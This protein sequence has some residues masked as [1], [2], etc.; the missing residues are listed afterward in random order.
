MDWIDFFVKWID[1]LDVIV[2]VLEKRE[3]VIPPDDLILR[4]FRETPLNT[5]KI[6]I[7]G[8]DP[9]PHGAADGLAFSVHPDYPSCGDFSGLSRRPWEILE[10]LF[11][12][13]G[14]QKKKGDLTCW[15]RQGV[16]LLNLAL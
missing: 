5:L 12:E 15:A 3:N 9:Y 2:G 10:N 4:P 7:L 1:E 6:V 13:I 11:D 16:F 14:S 8:L